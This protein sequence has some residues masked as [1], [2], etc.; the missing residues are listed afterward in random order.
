MSLRLLG[1]INVLRIIRIIV[2][3]CSCIKSHEKEM[4]PTIIDQSVREK[5]S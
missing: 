1:L 3:V 2:V 4:L 5:E